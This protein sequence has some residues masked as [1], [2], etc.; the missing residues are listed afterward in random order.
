MKKMNRMYFVRHGENRANLTKEF[1]SRRVDYALTEKGVLQAQQTAEALENKSIDEIYASPLKRAAQTAEIIAERLDLPVKI[2]DELREIDVGELEMGPP[3]AEAWAFHNQVLMDWLTGKHEVRFPG[4][5]DY[6]HLFLRV[7]VAMHEIFDGKEGQNVTVVSHGGIFMITL[8]ELC[9]GTDTLS[10]LSQ[11]ADNCSI[12]EM[13]VHTEPG[14]A[15]EAK[16]VR[17][18]D[19]SHLYGEAAELVSGFPED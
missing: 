11:P 1:S 15:I 14:G 2:L 17:W 19:T 8:P 7:Q 13:L 5:D 6:I 10:L 9:P 4:G 18:A 16:V 3:S 12:T